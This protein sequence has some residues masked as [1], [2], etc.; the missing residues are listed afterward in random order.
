MAEDAI[1]TGEAQVAVSAANE[2]ALVA[3]EVLLAA[4]SDPTEVQHLEAADSDQEKKVVLTVLLA[5][6]DLVAEAKPEVHQHQD[7]KADF[8]QNAHHEDQKIPQ[9]ERQDV[10]KV[11]RMHQEKEDQ[12]KAN[13]HLLIFL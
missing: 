9:T 13:I 5:K 2:K 10:L 3:E 12:E 7:V 11:H 4:V 8:H 6:A 1:T